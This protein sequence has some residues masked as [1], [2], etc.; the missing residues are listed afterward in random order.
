[1]SLAIAQINNAYPNNIVHIDKE[2]M[3]IDSVELAEGTKNKEGTEQEVKNLASAASRIYKKF[4]E[5]KYDAFL[6]LIETKEKIVF[7]YYI[8]EQLRRDTEKENV[9]GNTRKI[10]GQCLGF[11]R[12]NKNEQLVTLDKYL[13]FE[14]EANEETFLETDFLD[15]SYDRNHEDSSVFNDKDFYGYKTGTENYPTILNG[16]IYE[17]ASI[18]SGDKIVFD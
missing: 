9:D 4:D 1:M 5:K 10:K 17:V 6:I 8:E 7:G 14:F 11:Y 13:T 18:N 2:K 12:I 3:I 16:G 15:V